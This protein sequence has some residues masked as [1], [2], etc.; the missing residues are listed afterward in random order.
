MPI[1]DGLVANKIK[2]GY[3][4]LDEIVAA[5]IYKYSDCSDNQLEYNRIYLSDEFDRLRKGDKNVYLQHLR[6]LVKNNDKAYTHLPELLVILD[7]IKK[8]QNIIEFRNKIIS[9]ISTSTLDTVFANIGE[10]V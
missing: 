10:L 6:N 5:Y 8:S 4:W 7:K 2:G 9:I 1:F 3:D